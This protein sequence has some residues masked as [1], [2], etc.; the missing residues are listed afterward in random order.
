MDELKN[1]MFE[2]IEVNGA[3]NVPQ[4]TS[5][6]LSQTDTDIFSEFHQFDDAVPYNHPLGVPED[7]PSSYDWNTQYGADLVSESYQFINSARSIMDQTFIPTS[8]H[9]P[10]G[11]IAA[12]PY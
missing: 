11:Y 12:Y 6:E 1:W 10:Q 4:N 7:S 8:H 3:D 5:P 9:Q 2:R